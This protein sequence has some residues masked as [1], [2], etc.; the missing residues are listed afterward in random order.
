[1]ASDFISRGRILS[2]VVAL[3]AVALWLTVGRDGS[4]TADSQSQPEKPPPPPYVPVPVPNNRGR[5]VSNAFRGPVHPLLHGQTRLAVEAHWSPLGE[6]RDRLEEHVPESVYRLFRELAPAAPQETYTE[7]E[8]SAF[9]P[10]T[11]PAVGDVWELRPDDMARILRQFHPR[12]S[13]NLVALGRRAGPNGAFAT[14]RAVSPEYLDIVF[15]LHAEFDIA[16]NM[17]LTPACFLGRMIVDRE[18]GVVSCFRMWVPAERP[19]NVHLTVAQSMKPG[20]SIPEVFRKIERGDLVIARRDIV[21][22][23]QME[24]ASANRELPESLAWS[25]AVDMETALHRLKSAFYVFE[26]ID[27]VPWTEAVAVAGERAKPI[28]AIVLWGALDDQSC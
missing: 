11:L 17:W 26:N 1:M 7:R 28:M 19:L 6:G 15:R 20:G 14:L 10:E 4:E 25:D 8:L 22:V 5:D 18:S 12:P 13:L 21:R 24:L 16:Q 23:E 9:M 2:I 3:C 27:W